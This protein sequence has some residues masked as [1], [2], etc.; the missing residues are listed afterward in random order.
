MK[1]LLILLLFSSCWDGEINGRKYRLKT[2]CIKDHVELRP[3]A[4]MVGKAVTTTLHPVVI[5]DCYGATDT[6][7]KDLK[8]D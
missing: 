5:C 6:I 7:W 2:P 4:M 3:M 8:I 1:K